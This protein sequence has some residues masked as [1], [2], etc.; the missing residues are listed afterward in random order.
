MVQIMSSKEYTSLFPRDFVKQ[1]EFKTI[2]AVQSM[3][4]KKMHN[5]MIDYMKTIRSI[6]KSESLLDKFVYSTI[7]MLDVFKFFFVKLY[8]YY[9]RTN[10][11][12]FSLIRNIMSY[13]R[14]LKIYKNSKC[15]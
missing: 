11:N 5:E 1:Y 9:R 4:L 12:P 2:Y 13:R 8:F 3:R 14:G 6:Q 7:K 10:I 15:N